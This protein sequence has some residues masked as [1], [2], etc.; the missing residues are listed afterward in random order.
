MRN[1]GSGMGEMSLEE[2]QLFRML[3]GFF[4]RDR[5]IWNMSVRSVCGGSISTSVNTTAPPAGDWI[6]MSGC[7][8]TIVDDQDN[9]RMVIEFEADFSRYIEV[10]QMERSQRLPV[11]LQDHGIRYVSISPADFREMTDPRSS[12]DLISFLKD[13]FGVDDSGE[14]DS[15][16]D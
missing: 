5:V 13:K 10:S 9:P 14:T 2:A 12:L 7:L 15:N 16:G 3:S 4:G 6:D 8:F 1:V 11:L